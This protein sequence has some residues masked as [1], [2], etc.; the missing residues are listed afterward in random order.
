MR[1]AQVV[2]GDIVHRQDFRMRPERSVPATLAE[3]VH[4]LSG[5]PRAVVCAGAGPKIDGAIRLTNGGWLLS[6]SQIA[7]ATGAQTVLVINDFEAAAW[8]LAGVSDA[9]VSPIGGAGPLE[10]GHRVALGPG[11]GLGVGGLMWDGTSFR[12]LPG[13]GG[14]VAIGPRTAAEVAIFER[15]ATLWPETQI[16]GTLTFEAEAMLSGTGLPFLYQAV[17]GKSG[18]DAA[19]VFARAASG[20]PIARDTVELFGNH[21]AALAGNLAVTLRATGGIFLVGGVA[22]ANPQMFDAQF[23]QAFTA[24][25]RFSDLR[26]ECGIYLMKIEDFGLRGCVNAL[27]SERGAI[28]PRV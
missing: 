11:T 28:A 1:V 3:F 14:H 27:M 12:V 18:V 7:E 26:A 23:W 13:E 8:S 17:G 15:F 24:G 25:G 2:R 21:L 20:E 22:Q 16:D 5:Q 19:G 9:D 6:Q 4:G 10:I